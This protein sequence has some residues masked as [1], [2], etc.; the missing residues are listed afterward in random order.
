MTRANMTVPEVPAA[1]CCAVRARRTPWLRRAI[2][3]VTF[4]FAFTFTLNAQDT[5]LLIVS[6]LSGEDRFARQYAEWGGAIVRSA[7]ER[8][9]VPAAN[10]V[11]LAER[12]DVHAAVRDRSTRANLEREIGA[13]AARAGAQ[14]RVLILLFGHGSFQAGESRI[15]LPGPD[16]NA[17]ELAVLLSALRTQRVAIVNT[18]SASGGFVQDLA[19]PNRIVITATRTGMEANETVFGG[20]FAAALTGDAA[21]L[22]K[23]GR[24]SLLEAFEYTRIEVERTYTSTNRLQT[25][26]AVIDAVGDGRGTG[27]V[28]VNSPHAQ[29]ARTFFL[30]AGG[31]AAANASPQLRALYDEKAR[32][33]SALDALRSRREAMPEAEYET[34]LEKLLVELARNA[35]QIRRAEGGGT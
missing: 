33:E 14:D 19:A 1:A 2:T 9:G 32:I 7:V 4:T 23:D 8:M 18:A 27:A 16:I 29:G 13:L 25:E 30:G 3:A 35:Q 34:E 10:V 24:V 20:H 26:H 5:H 6:G 28:A 17:K 15:N 31:A 21:D 12:A 22:D 11:W